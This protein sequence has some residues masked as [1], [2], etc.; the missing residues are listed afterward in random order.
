MYSIFYHIKSTNSRLSQTEN[1]WDEEKDVR[2]SDDDRSTKGL[3]TEKIIDRS[4]CRRHSPKWLTISSLTANLV[5]GITCIALATR[6]QKD[7]SLG[8][9]SP[10][11]HLVEYHIANVSTGFMTKTP[12]MGFPTDETDKLWE[13]LYQ[14]GDSFISEEEAKK[15]AYP[16]VH[17][18]ETKNYLVELEVFHQLHCLNDIRKAFYPER[19]P[20]KWPYKEDRVTI[21]RNKHCIDI[22]RGTLMC[23]ADVA[24][25]SWRLN[26]PVG[27]VLAPQLETTHTCRN[28][29]K[30]VEW[31]REHEAKGLRQELTDRE[32]EAFLADPPFDQS[33]WEDQSGFWQAFPGNPFFKQWRE[34]WNE[35]AEG[36]E[37]WEKWMLEQKMKEELKA[38]GKEDEIE[39][40]DEASGHA[41]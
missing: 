35:T 14:F 6:P 26:V 24:P 12:Y 41:H 30:I 4:H 33:P 29:T 16:T 36:R 32:R 9:Y 40:V 28:F 18:M 2:L 31:A 38:E 25:I 23:N 7:P 11:N 20:G 13:D 1:S 34:G 27:R 10:V 17:E 19:Y 5:L 8:V 21:N 39:F 22:L 15:L 37:F 3:L